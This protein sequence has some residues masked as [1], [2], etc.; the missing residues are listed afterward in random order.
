M[1]IVALKAELSSSFKWKSLTACP[2]WVNDH[3]NKRRR[4]VFKVRRH[5]RLIMAVDSY[6]FS[7]P[8][9][10]QNFGRDSSADTHPNFEIKIVPFFALIDDS[11]NSIS[12]ESQIFWNWSILEKSSFKTFSLNGIINFN[13]ILS[14]YLNHFL[15][16][17]IS[18]T[19]STSVL[20][21]YSNPED[22]E[23]PSKLLI[24]KSIVWSRRRW[25]EC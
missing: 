2:I 24:M 16:L 3:W 10:W 7:E 9:F 17:S 5:S 18:I 6:T 23:T 13:L 20:A 19:S 4:Q 21:S 15:S 1:L 11:I 8:Q 22:F 12:V 14:C 25:A